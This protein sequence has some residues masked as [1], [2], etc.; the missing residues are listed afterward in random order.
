MFLFSGGY[1]AVTA[2]KQKNPNLKV[3]ISIGGGREDGSH[4]FSTL[5]TSAIRRRDFIRSVVTF[6]KQFNFDGVDLHWQYPAAEELGG[7]NTDR[8][9]F[10]LLLEELS[11]VYN[12][13]S[14]VTIPH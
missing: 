11:E 7:R 12:S 1:L 6:L 5:I 14:S 10:E 9:Y 13:S 3:L 4:R 8:E 2:L